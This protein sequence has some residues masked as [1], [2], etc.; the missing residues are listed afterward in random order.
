MR[1]NQYVAMSTGLSRRSADKAINEGRVTVNGNPA[2][3]GQKIDTVDSVAID[4]KPIKPADKLITVILNKPVGYVCSRSGQ[5]NKTVYELLPP[6]LHHLKP[7]GRLDKDT[8]GLLVLTNDGILAHRL[9][10]PSF[11]K[12]KIYKVML[13]KQLVPEDKTKI[14]RGIKLEDGISKLKF[15]S[16]VHDQSARA[17]VVSMHEGRNRQIRR[18]FAALGYRVTKLQRIAFG[19]Y[20]LGTLNSGKYIVS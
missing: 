17:F 7:V 19:D 2:Q 9:T 6:G 15:S 18:T 5:G 4:R 16:L 20:Q 13:N 12:K 10:H 3:T 8:S 14:S 1:I 11:D